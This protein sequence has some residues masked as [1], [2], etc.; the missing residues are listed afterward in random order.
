MRAAAAV[1][2]ATAALTALFEY[3]SP[4]LACRQWG[5]DFANPVG[6]AAGFDKTGELYPFLAAAG[7]GFVEC[8]TFTAEAQPGNPRPRVFRFPGER[9]LVNRLG[10]NNPG[11]ARAALTLR[12]QRRRAPRGISIGKSRRTELADAAADHRQSLLQLAPFADYVALN[13]SSPNT[14]GLRSLQK[15]AALRDLIE[16][17]RAALAAANP[18]VPLLL[19][20]APDLSD[21]EL[22]SSLEAASA[23]GAAGFILTNTTTARAAGSAAAPVEGGL[24]GEPLRARST[25][26]IRRA[27]G[28]TGGRIPLI[29]VGGI[30][31]GEDAEAKIRAGAALVQLYTGYIFEGPSLP[32][33]I[34]RHLDRLCR[35][36]GCAFADLIGAQGEP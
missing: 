8:G 29:G 19:K 32:R 4:L 22:E 34:A 1:P 31:S 17:A 30:F 24:S 18:R 26:L 10:F 25:A 7:F 16:D 2:G 14:P 33:R 6:L 11:A 20:L 28:L 23:A 21:Q 13:V 9:A 27:Y 12:A 15:N 35:R 3:R 36:Q 5:I